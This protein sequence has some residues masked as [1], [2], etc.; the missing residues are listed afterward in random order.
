[1]LCWHLTPC[2]GTVQCAGS[3]LLQEQLTDRLRSRPSAAAGQVVNIG[4]AGKATDNVT[5][6]VIMM[7]DN[8]KP[9]YLEQAGLLLL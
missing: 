1:M 7:K 9:R 2:G 3:R 6:R 5:Q 4:T 8:E